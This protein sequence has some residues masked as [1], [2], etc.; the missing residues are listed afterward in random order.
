MPDMS[1]RIR[2]FNSLRPSY[3]SKTLGFLINNDTLPAAAGASGSVTTATDTLRL[4]QCW[5][6]QPVYLQPHHFW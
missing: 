6:G 4:T 2:I 3:N 5:L 1:L